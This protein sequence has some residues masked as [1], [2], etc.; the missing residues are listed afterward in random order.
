M[1]TCPKTAVFF[2]SGGQGSARRDGFPQKGKE[3]A[4]EGAV[5]GRFSENA[6]KLAQIPAK[7]PQLHGPLWKT[8]ELRQDGFSAFAGQ[9][10]DKAQREAPPT[11]G[12]I[13]PAALL[14]RQKKRD[15]VLHDIHERL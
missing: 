11:G 5:W 7:I 14:T 3:C 12:R 15:R 10:S 13:C 8:A 1:S 4:K 2:H 9:S 6:V